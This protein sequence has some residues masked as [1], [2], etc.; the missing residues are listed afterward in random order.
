MTTKMWFKLSLL[1][2]VFILFL[3]INIKLFNSA[4]KFINSFLNTYIILKI[5]NK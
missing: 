5:S 2:K 1:N 4:K 3:I